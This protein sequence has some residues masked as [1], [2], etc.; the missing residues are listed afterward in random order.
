MLCVLTTGS[1][2]YDLLPVT[3]PRMRERGT[4]IESLVNNACWQEKITV[5][6]DP[7]LSAQH[8]SRST[9]SRKQAW[10]EGEEFASEKRAE[11]KISTKS[12]ASPYP[13]T[14]PTQGKN[15]NQAR[16]KRDVK[17]KIPR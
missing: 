8:V 16:P 14:P 7:V 4:K 13:T 1:W 15:A 5:N 10:P 6:F 3:P 17:L 2:M 11:T 9:R 12:I